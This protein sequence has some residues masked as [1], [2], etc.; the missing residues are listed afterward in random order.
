MDISV[1]EEDEEMEYNV[2]ESKSSKIVSKNVEQK[3]EPKKAKSAMFI[4]AWNMEN[5]ELDD[6]LI[7]VD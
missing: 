3:K 2:S 5:D 4:P 6:M 7:N 1:E